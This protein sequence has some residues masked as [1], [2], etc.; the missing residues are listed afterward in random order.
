VQTSLQTRLET[1]QDAA[2]R[3]AI[4]TLDNAPIGLR[5]RYQPQT[6][7]IERGDTGFRI[8]RKT[9]IPFYLI[10]EANPQIDWEKDL[11][12]VGQTI[13]L[14]SRDVTMPKLPLQNKRI[15]VDLDRQMLY[16]YENN[17][18][19]FSWAIS[20]GQDNAPTSP[21]IYQ[22]LN[23]NETAYGSSSTLCD[24][25]GLVCGQWEMSWF[26]GI[27]EVQPG[28]VNGFHGAVLLPNGNYLGGEYNVGAPYTFGCVMSQDSNAKL[29]YD[30]AEVGTVVE[31]ISS[32]YA[33]MSDLAQQA[34]RTT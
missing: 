23:H 11:L 29:L 30:W 3:N 2:Q 10:Q 12:I 8:A 22:I 24:A 15:V 21:G 4:P 18:L 17:Q 34:T 28:L 26:M 27:Y 5:I 33:P 19:V 31:I 25:A 9:G 20:S 1:L 6:Y 7:A 13:S 16:A 32:E 14:P